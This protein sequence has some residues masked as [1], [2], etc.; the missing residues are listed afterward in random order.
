MP[1]T[2]PFNKPYLVGKELDYIAEA[3]RRG[4]TAGD[5]EFSDRCRKLL[6]ARLGGTHVMLTASCTAA[7][8]IAALLCDFA[9]GDEV[10]LPSFTF[11]T[12]ASAFVRAG[13]RPVFVDVRA[14][15][16]NM[17][18]GMVAA[19]ITPRT[20]AIVPVHYAGVPC[21]L[22]PLLAL[23]RDHHL[24]VIEDA[25]QSLGATYRGVPAG[26]LGA[27]GC[28]SFHETKNVHC[29]QGGALCVN[30]ADD[31]PRAEMLRDRGTDRQRF[32][33]GE[34]PSYTWMDL[35]SA[36]GL[37]EL[38]AAYLCAQL[39]AL[40]DI[41]ARR[42]RIAG[43]YHD[44]LDAL[45]QRECVRLLAVPPACGTNHHLF[46]ILLA[47]GVTR[48]ALLSH[49]RAERI[50]AVQHYEPLHRSAFART[51]GTQPTLPV[52]D[53]VSERLLR[54]PLYYELTEADVERIAAAITAF[55][56]NR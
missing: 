23:A 22:D 54:L 33:R 50:G 43:W 1:T 15:T 42:A 14:D 51:L 32:F 5:G 4:N 2:I 45:V 31:V 36:F 49:L 56:T 13:A 11:P 12:T 38:Q 9:P 52:T 7:L 30:R 19:A 26:T 20:R 34:V 18:V 10:V 16:L 48:A 27:L 53:A 21:D 47:D 37:S 40:D 17:D 24:R 28:L 35:G 3:V 46:P 25:A 8:E 39:E 6:A 29:G 55:F 44:A 41:A